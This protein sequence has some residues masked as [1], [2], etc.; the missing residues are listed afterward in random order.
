MNVLILCEGK[1]TRLGRVRRMIELLQEMNLNLYT[2]S[3]ER[4]SEYSFISQ[5]SVPSL[6]VSLVSRI[7]R[8]LLRVLRWVIPFYSIRVFI[9]EITTGIRRSCITSS[10]KWDIII[11][12]HIDFLPLAVKLK[13]EQDAKILFDV[14]DYYP[15]EFED[16][17]MFKWLEAGYRKQVFKHLLCH[18]DAVISVSK[19]LVEGL[20]DEYGINAHLV[21]NIPTYYNLEPSEVKGDVIRLV[22]HGSANADRFLGNLIQ[23]VKKLDNRFT[24]D[25]YL[26]GSEN[27]LS[28]LKKMAGGHS[29]IRFNEPVAFE[30]LVVELNNYDIAIFLFVPNTFNHR[31]GLSNKLFEA[32][33][34]RLMIITTPLENN[35]NIVNEYA[36]GLV[37]KSFIYE[38]AIP[39]INSVTK[40]EVALAKKASNIAAKSLCFEEERKKLYSVLQ[41]L[42]DT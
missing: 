26:V 1:I 24:L 20:K 9:T 8:F 3:G 38:E 42:I 28:R 5:M 30:K 22:H 15:R 41:T 16:Y 18:C 12:E 2:L 19:G 29:R 14:R 13:K 33:Q 34:A 31:H 4:T 23:L 6:S 25:L 10:D 21:R 37:L 40:D 7:Y 35:A 36:C 27:D 17:F 32:I 39:L 11:V